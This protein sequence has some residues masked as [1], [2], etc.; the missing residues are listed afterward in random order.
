MEERGLVNKKLKNLENVRYVSG[1]ED[2]GFW[3]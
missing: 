3:S 1:W 2:Y